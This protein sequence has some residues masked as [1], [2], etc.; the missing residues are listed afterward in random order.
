MCTSLW[1]QLRDV[2]D[3]TG[4]RCLLAECKVSS[5]LH[6]DL[7]QC[8]ERRSST[9][10]T[11]SYRTGSDHLPWKKG[12]VEHSLVFRQSALWVPSTECS[13]YKNHNC[14][15]S[16]S[17]L[18]EDADFTAET[19]D[20]GEGVGLEERGDATGL[21]RTGEGVGLEGEV[22]AIIRMR[23]FEVSAM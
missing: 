22:G 10:K 15:I 4:K 11:S 8:E 6:F 9:G 2:V 18:P 19:N 12:I 20:T 5:I 13:G 3:K 1:G 17:S 14:N 16:L 21:V 7:L 23:S